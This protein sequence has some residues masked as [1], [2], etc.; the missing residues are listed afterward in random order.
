MSPCLVLH[1][2]PPLTPLLT[3]HGQA[4]PVLLLMCGHSTTPI[5]C[6]S[7]T[8]FQQSAQLKLTLS[9]PHL[10]PCLINS[11]A[12]HAPTPEQAY[13]NNQSL[14]GTSWLVILVGL[15]QVIF[16]GDPTFHP[17]PQGRTLLALKAKHT[18]HNTY[19]MCNDLLLNTRSKP[20]PRRETPPAFAL[21]GRLHDRAEAS[22]A[23]GGSYSSQLINPLCS[24]P[25]KS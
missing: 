22:H 1:Q 20:Q 17:A 16:S 11:A 19:C 18:Q 5:I 12:N 14:N 7:S 4:I 10:C 25:L 2:L 6:P 21:R 9:H 24:L 3:Q 13:P 23:C 15:L 8:M